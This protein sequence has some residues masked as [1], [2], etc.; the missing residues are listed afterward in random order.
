MTDMPNEEIVVLKPAVGH[1]GH[2]LSSTAET[3][4]NSHIIANGHTTNKKDN[5]D[6]VDEA[7]K[8]Q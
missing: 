1:V 4:L 6:L 2:V 3:E 5:D 7:K 8:D